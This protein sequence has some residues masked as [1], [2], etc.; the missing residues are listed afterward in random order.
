MS[1]GETGSKSLTHFS[2]RPSLERLWVAQEARLADQDTVVTGGFKHVQWRTLLSAFYRGS[3]G[4]FNRDFPKEIKERP[5]VIVGLI[6][7][8]L[9]LLH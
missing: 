9:V 8:P 6:K 7:P 4:R 2:E 5:T 1:C 3:R